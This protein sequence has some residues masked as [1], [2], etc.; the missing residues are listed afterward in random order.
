MDGTASRAKH[1]HIVQCWLAGLKHRLV[2]NSLDVNEVL[3]VHHQMALFVRRSRDTRS[4]DV[5]RSQVHSPRGQT[6][7]SLG[8]LAAIRVLSPLLCLPL[9]LD[10]AGQGGSFADG[11]I[12]EEIN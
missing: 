1:L 11:N 2:C 5:T 3:F 8:R 6:F 9:P 12:R 10:K 4:H 7:A